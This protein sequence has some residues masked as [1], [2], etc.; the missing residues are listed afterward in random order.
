MSRLQWKAEYSVGDALM[1]QQHQG[2]FRLIDRLEDTSLDVG[3]MRATLAELD[4]YVDEHLQEEED[5]LRSCSYTELESHIRQHDEF[6]EWL[7]A[8]KGS[9]DMPHHDVLTLGHNLQVFLR[10]WLLNHIMSADQA[11]KDWV[12]AQKKGVD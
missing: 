9:M 10:D 3:A 1:D 11:Y 12:V 7:T 5:I 4:R 8:A 6:R 2:L